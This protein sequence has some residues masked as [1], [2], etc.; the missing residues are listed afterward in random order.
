MY[1]LHSRLRRC[2]PL[3][4]ST[5]SNP[6]W[7]QLVSSSDEKVDSENRDDSDTFGCLAS[8]SNIH[9]KFLKEKNDIKKNN[10]TFPKISYNKNLF[11]H[12]KQDEDTVG[13]LGNYQQSFIIE[14]WKEFKDVEYDEIIKKSMTGH[15]DDSEDDYYYFLRRNTKQRVE[16]KDGSEETSAVE[17]RGSG[18]EDTLQSSG[19][20]DINGV[21]SPDDGF[22]KLAPLKH[23]YENEKGDEGDERE[24]RYQEARWER[25]HSPQYY[26]QQMKNLC[27]E[28][29]LSAALKILEEEM[30]AVRAKPN[31]FCFQVLINACGR[32][33][34]TKKAFQLYNQ[35]KKRGLKV[36]PV[37]YTGLFNAC[38]NSPWPETDGLKRATQ[39]REQLLQNGYLFNQIISHAMIK[40][41]GRCGDINTAFQIVDDMIEQG[42]LVTTSTI[43]FLLQACISDKETGFRHAIMVWRKMRELKLSP[44][45]FSYNLLIRCIVDCGAGDQRLTSSLLEGVV[46]NAVK[47]TKREMKKRL[48]TEK[49]LV[50]AN[51]DKLHASESRNTV[52]T[53]EVKDSLENTEKKSEGISENLNNEQLYSMTEMRREVQVTAGQNHVLPNLL[54]RTLATGAV[55]GLGPLDQPQDRL[56]LLGGPSGI[57]EQM[58]HDRVNADLKTVTQ[59]VDSL[60]SNTDAEE[61]LLRSMENIGLKPDTQFCNMLIRKRIFRGDV[62]GGK[63]I[64]DLMQQHHLE[65][66][67]IT[68]GCLALGCH[69]LQ[70]ATDLLQDM[71][72]AKFTPN[73]EIM[74][75]LVKNS[76]VRKNYF[77]T[78]EILKEMHH[79]D[80]SPDENLLH[81]LECGRQ[82]ARNTMLK[83][84]GDDAE[85]TKRKLET[86]KIFL[87]E[88]KTWLKK[89]PVQLQDHPWAQYRSVSNKT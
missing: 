4:Q 39:L 88:Y 7:I 13:S 45:I 52:S 23:D 86:I 34:Y 36:Q 17:V 8:G 61:A 30:P 11:Q 19:N 62:E 1:S 84:E 42:L 65:P 81:L 43:N 67:L 85:M 6:N 24:R 29:K 25:R 50:L 72:T 18:K 33:G 89:S 27:K 22:G 2:Q 49:V 78:L 9:E 59:L 31:D 21:A 87:M 82:K 28:K 63:D 79:R 70:S 60:P 74:T 5:I 35:M 40:A 54:G 68:F 64:L 41:F 76:L 10:R 56:A 55:V 32:A 16:K 77:Y 46:G 3:W 58:S 44:D 12:Q 48:I 57:L 80:I 75:M 71:D 51:E 38:A 14:K 47:G 69:H 15:Q 37:A 66:D 73:L 53:Q 83:M 20:G 26:G